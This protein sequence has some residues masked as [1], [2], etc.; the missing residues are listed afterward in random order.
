MTL[1]RNRVALRTSDIDTFTKPGAYS[2]LNDDD[3]LGAVGDSLLLWV[4]AA[5]GPKVGSIEFE[6][7]AG[8]TDSYLLTLAGVGHSLLFGTDPGEILVG[9]NAIG[10]AT[11]FAAAVEALSITGLVVD[12][13]DAVV[14]LTYNASNRASLTALIGAAVIVPFAGPRHVLQ[15]ATNLSD[16]S[17]FE[18][19]SGDDSENWSE[20][21][22]AEGGGG[23]GEMNVQADWT[24]AD[25]GEDSFIQNKPTLGTMAAEAAADYYSATEADGLLDDK[26][27]VAG[28][29]LT[30]PV[31]NTAANGGTISTGTVVV[32][33]EL[34]YY[35]NGGA[36]ALD[37]P[38]SACSGAVLITNNGSAGAINL[39]DWTDT[40]GDDFTTVNGDA[41]MCT[42]VSIN[43]THV[44]N[45][46][47]LP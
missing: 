4:L 30:G 15:R 44:L 39:G 45:I 12:R 5:R 11:N 46:T 8:G 16:G 47:A 38:T 1:L 25:S 10:S 35:T 28:G 36:H 26:L 33:G 37:P 14:T 2:V 34:R 20:W 27:D 7:V 42:F 17:V 3:D 29:T 41:F 24:E 31:D 18:R 32:S 22:A 6:T 23:S 9:A 19:Y 40:T 43:G 21:T 13:A